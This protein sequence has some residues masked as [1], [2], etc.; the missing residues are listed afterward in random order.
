[1]FLAA[2]F[3][4]SKRWKQPTCQSTDEWIH[5]IHIVWY[6]HTMEYY[7]A[8]KRMMY[9]YLLQY[10]SILIVQFSS[11]QSL[12]RVRLFATPWIAA[13]Q[14]SLSITNSRSSPRLMSIE[15]VMPSSRLILCHPLLLP[16]PIPPS[17]RVFSNESTLLMK[18]QAKWKTQR[19]SLT[20]WCYLY[21]I[22]RIGKFTWKKSTL[23]VVGGQWEERTG[24]WHIL[25]GWSF[26][27]G[28]WKCFEIDGIDPY[29]TLWLD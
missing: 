28:W 5:K 25:A 19:K 12:S 16:P 26:V 27:M 15:S 23:M 29:T 10:D 18:W 17:I 3:T 14:A 22:S 13:R 4:T 2:P 24:D 11:V 20:V 1:M 9:W 21:E 8:I 7:L 6:F